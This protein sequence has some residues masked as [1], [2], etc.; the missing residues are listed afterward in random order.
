[1]D[2]LGNEPSRRAI[3]EDTLARTPAII[4]EH[5]AEGAT[6]DSTFHRDQLEA[7]DPSKSPK[8]PPSKVEV[9]NSDAY[10]LARQIMNEDLEGTKG[11]TTVLNLASD[12][13]PAGPWL[14][15][16]T[17]TQ[18]EAL[19][20][21]ST[22]YITLKEEYYPWPNIGKGSAAGIYSPGVV[23][24]KDELEKKSVDLKLEDRR[25]V[26]VITV[27]APRHRRVA[28]DGKGW[29]ETIVSKSMKEKIRL[30]YRMAG[31]NGQ[32]HMVLG[33]MGCGAYDC[34]P[35]L[36]AEMMRDTLLE[37]EFAGWFRRVVF[38][39]YSKS[40]YERRPTNFTTFSE[41]FK[42]VTINESPAKSV[43]S[44]STTD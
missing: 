31:H 42:D 12:L 21:A 29:A 34:P 22:L 11:K 7:L 35:R 44:A 13:L 4:V 14:E 15:V 18:E 41:V 40:P 5:A 30:V 23:I 37:P 43:A 32:T 24:F 2:V 25:L 28:P 8:H 27:A 17:A 6:A 9:Y 39:C 3:A 16:M 10:I 33:A 26:S 19:C 1:M 38:A 20:Y 36:V